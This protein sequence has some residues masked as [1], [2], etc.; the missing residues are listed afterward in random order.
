MKNN[1][2]LNIKTSTLLFVYFSI[3]NTVIFLSNYFLLTSEFYHS[4]FSEQLTYEQIDVLV[5]DGE[6]WEWLGYII[7]PTLILL[8][9]S[10]ISLCLNIGLYFVIN[11]LDFKSVFKVALIAEFI[12]IIPSIFK[13]LWF[14]TFEASYNISDIQLFSPLSALSI[15]DEAAVQQNQSWLVYPLQ[16]LNLFEVAYWLLLAKGVSEV[17]KKDFTESFE[18]VMASYGTG[19]VLWIVTIMFITVTYGI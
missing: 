6:K 18:L 10:I 7:S 8:K 11:K 4:S 13:L 16:T 9:L 1:N 15:F 12:F 19:L 17:I 14:A 5:Q 2:I 3:Y